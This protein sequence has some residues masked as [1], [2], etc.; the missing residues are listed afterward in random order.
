MNKRKTNVPHGGQGKLYN[1][2]HRKKEDLRQALGKVFQTTG[3]KR[4]CKNL[5]E[6]VRGL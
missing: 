2:L 5:T 3:I 4:H 6:E 1:N